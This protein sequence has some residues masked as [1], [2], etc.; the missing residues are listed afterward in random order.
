MSEPFGTNGKHPRLIV[1]RWRIV[2][3]PHTDNCIILLLWGLP[4]W[5][6]GVASY[7][8]PFNMRI[9][10]PSHLMG[11]EFPNTSSQ[12]KEK[13]CSKKLMFQ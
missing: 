1:G 9:A 8:H 3:S 2:L 12:A 4:T 13:E 11:S 5:P 7:F 6:K 10:F